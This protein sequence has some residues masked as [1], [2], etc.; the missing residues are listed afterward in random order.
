MPLSMSTYVCRIVDT[1]PPALCTVEPAYKKV[2][3]PAFKQD[4]RGIL[5]IKAQFVTL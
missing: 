5:R 1:G 4:R 3:Q 2:L